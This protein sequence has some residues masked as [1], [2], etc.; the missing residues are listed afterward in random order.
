MS[1]AGIFAVVSYLTS[2]RLKEIALRRAIGARNSDVIRLL[3]G[4]AFGW[5][6]VVLTIGVVGAMLASTVLRATV[7]GVIAL[8]VPL[9]A[10]TGGTYLLVAVVAMVVPAIRALRVDPAS[11]LRSE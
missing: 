4:Q 9:V 7:A 1:I 2:R 3:S 8:D 10:V 11:A 6:L 5:A